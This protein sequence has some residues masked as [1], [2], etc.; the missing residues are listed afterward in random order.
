[1]SSLT[2]AIVALLLASAP[3]GTPRSDLPLTP[4]QELVVSAAIEDT[5][6]R[7]RHLVAPIVLCL[8]V[9]LSDEPIED[10]LPP[11]RAAKRKKDK[12]PEPPPSAFRGAPPELL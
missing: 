11:P 1:M 8:D 3:A 10:L 4:D 7:P 9:Q 2:A 6:P 5:F 12:R